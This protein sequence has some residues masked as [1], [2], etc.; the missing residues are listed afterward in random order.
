MCPY[1][2]ESLLPAVLPL[3]H[4]LDAVGQGGQDTSRGGFECDGFAFEVYA[5]HPLGTHRLEH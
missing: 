1:L 2:V 5:I 4:E 3:D